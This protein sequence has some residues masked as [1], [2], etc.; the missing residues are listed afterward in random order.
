[1]KY[2]ELKELA[3]QKEDENWA[4]RKFLKFYD[5]LSDEQIDKLVYDTADAV[6]ANIEC[7]SCGQ[8]CKQLKPTLTAEDQQRL[9]KKLKVA[10]QQ[11]QDT[12]LEY[13]KSDDEP[14]CWQIKKAP[15]SFLKDKKCTVYEA[16]P[17]N[18]RDYPYLHEPGFS[19]RTMAM[20]ERTF[21]CPIVFEVM[22]KLK[23]QLAFDANDFAG[24]CR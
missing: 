19:S 5:D 21:T 2:D 10:V 9:A 4:F 3:K 13:V 16:R 11:L 7:T 12:Y 18:C 24:N 6:A 17:Q 15:C 22:E 1:M 8:C 23:E 14:A 20:L